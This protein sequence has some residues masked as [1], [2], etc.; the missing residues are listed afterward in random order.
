MIK[1]QRKKILQFPS[2]LRHIQNVDM[3]LQHEEC[4]SWGLLHSL[5]RL[6]CQDREYL[7]RVTCW[8]QLHMWSSLARSELARKACTGIQSSGDPIENLYDTEKYPPICVYCTTSVELNPQDAQCKDCCDKP[9]INK[10]WDWSDFYVLVC[11]IVPVYTVSFM[12][13]CS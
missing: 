10:N 7:Y 12:C 11:T 3:M 1:V 6:S 9:H 2:N 5:N 8:L 4:D 13:K